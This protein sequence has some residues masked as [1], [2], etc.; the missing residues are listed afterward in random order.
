M[1]K[2]HKEGQL[3]DDYVKGKP[4]NRG[5]TGRMHDHNEVYRRTG[6]RKAAIRAYCAGNKW[7]EENAK[8]V[9]NW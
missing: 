6:D 2:E 7:L 5:E 9:G 3:T 4:E 1:D 8:A